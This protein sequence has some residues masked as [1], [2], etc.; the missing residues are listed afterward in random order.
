MLLP[1]LFLFNFNL[2]DPKKSKLTKPPPPPKKFN[3]E[4]NQKITVLTK[5]LEKEK[6]NN[7]LKSHKSL[8]YLSS[9]ASP[10]HPSSPLSPHSPHHTLSSSPSPSLDQL[11][12]Q[13]E[14]GGLKKSLF[15][16]ETDE[17][18]GKNKNKNKNKNK[19]IKSFFKIHFFSLFPF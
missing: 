18:S 1:F 12:I 16:G 14:K 6:A 17:A 8:S 11:S 7:N 5:N 3:R 13:S 4:M 9:Y 2:F 19:K 10:P 15:E